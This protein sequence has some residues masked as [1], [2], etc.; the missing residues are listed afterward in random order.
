MAQGDL[1][2]IP[3]QPL[4]SDE[5][6]LVIEDLRIAYGALHSLVDNVHH[7]AEG[8]HW[9]A[10]ELA[11]ASK[12]LSSRTESAAS[13]LEEQSATMGQIGATVDATAERAHMAAAF[14]EANAHVA[15]KGGKV[16]AEVV[17]TMQEIHTSS[18]KISDIVGTI[19]GIA[20]QTNILAL[21]AAVEAARAGESGRGFAVV[22]SEVRG[23]AQRS[24]V[25]AREIKGLIATSMVKVQGGTLVVESAGQAMVEVV[26][27]ARQINYFLTEISTAAR[28]QA[29]GVKEAGQT[30]QFLDQATLRNA[31]L[32][33]QTAVAASEL[34]NEADTL[35]NELS[36]FRVSGVPIRETSRVFTTSLKISQI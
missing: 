22:A 17:S 16:F 31:A 20:F 32:V 14:A 24:A 25:A 34:Q 4:G 1:R 19:D 12:D 30:I 8:I 28:E 18:A 5:P 36:K 9:A 7:S 33:K 21:N 23:L 11:A 6:A 13:S 2:R 15:E 3:N 29:F 26:A 35:Q 27:N 10:Q